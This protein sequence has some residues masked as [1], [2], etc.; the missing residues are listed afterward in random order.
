VPTPLAALLP[1]VSPTTF[2]LLALDAAGTT[3]LFVTVADAIDESSRG[4]ALAPD[5]TRCA[6][7]VN[8]V[9]A[10][11]VAVV[12]SGSTWIP[13]PV[14]APGNLA[15][16]IGFDRSSKRHALVHGVAPQALVDYHE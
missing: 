3:H 4:T 16:G 8:D 14:A 1:Q 7:L 11:I 13:T 9:S 12:Q 6:A 5:G 2:P 10:G 15:M